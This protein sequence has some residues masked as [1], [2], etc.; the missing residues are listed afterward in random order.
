MLGHG[1]PSHISNR[2]ARAVSFAHMV[3]AVSFAHMVRG[4]RCRSAPFVQ[5]GCCA[6]HSYAATRI[7]QTDVTKFAAP[8]FADQ[9]TADI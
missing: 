3:R 7:N 1:D 8:K 5:R 4:G 9:T 6:P 2:G